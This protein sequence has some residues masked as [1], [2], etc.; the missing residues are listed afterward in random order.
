MAPRGARSEAPSCSTPRRAGLR[1]A[2]RRRAWWPPWWSCWGQEVARDGVGCVALREL[3][4]GGA[5]NKGCVRK[6]AVINCV[7]RCCLTPA[8]VCWQTPPPLHLLGTH[9]RLCPAR[10][11]VSSPPDPPRATDR[12]S[13]SIIQEGACSQC[14]QG[15]C[16]WPAGRPC[17]PQPRTRPAAAVSSATTP[18]ACLAVWSPGLGSPRSAH[19]L[20]V[21]VCRPR[22]HACP[23]QLLH[24]T[25]P[26][27]AKG[28]AHGRAH[29]LAYRRMHD[30]RRTCAFTAPACAR[31]AAGAHRYMGKTSNTKSTSYSALPAARCRWCMQAPHSHARGH[32]RRQLH[33]AD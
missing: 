26:E 20:R 30:D 22:Q 16:A 2:A 14:M 7:A 8:F 15:G 33:A 6:W 11:A 25:L 23:I 32:R 29:S 3:C 10:P 9:K 31:C 17:L 12:P 18:T 24:R 28:W 27:T 13:R 4:T 19:V 1:S 5:N 21:R